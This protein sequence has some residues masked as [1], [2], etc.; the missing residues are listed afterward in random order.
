MFTF[1][2]LGS[3]AVGALLAATAYCICRNEI[4]RITER[5]PEGSINGTLESKVFGQSAFNVHLGLRRRDGRQVATRQKASPPPMSKSYIWSKL[6]ASAVLETDLRKMP[7]RIREAE[8]AIRER[9]SSTMPIDLA[10]RQ[11]ITG[12]K[13][14]LKELKR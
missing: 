5:R 4:V 6:Y 3:I 13:V 2:I 7:Q 14:R 1:V 12:A 9:F 10:E 8:W 11:I